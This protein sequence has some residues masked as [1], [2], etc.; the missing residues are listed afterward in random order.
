MRMLGFGH[1]YKPKPVKPAAVATE[2]AASRWTPTRI[3]F[4]TLGIVGVLL[5]GA[6]TL[7]V[8]VF[9]ATAPAVLTIGAAVMVYLAWPKKK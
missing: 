9:A 1:T 2:K 4:V 6:L 7:T 5:F 8:P 3:V